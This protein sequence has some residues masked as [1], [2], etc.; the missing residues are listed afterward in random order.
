MLTNWDKLPDRMRIPEVRP[1][2]DILNKKRF[3]LAV[4]RAFDLV[5]ALVL[6][7]VLALPMLVIAVWILSLIHI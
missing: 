2:Y 4:K 3:Q 6:L 1:Y 5:A 7:A